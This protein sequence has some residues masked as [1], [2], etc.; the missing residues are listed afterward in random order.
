MCTHS[1][2]W[3]VLLEWVH[4]DSRRN[5]LIN[6]C[7][8]W[9]V[10]CQ[11]F[12]DS[13]VCMRLY[14]LNDLFKEI[15][16]LFLHLQR[17]LL[18]CYLF[19]NNQ[20]HFSFRGYKMMSEFF[21]IF[22]YVF[23][24]EKA[25]CNPNIVWLKEDVPM[26]IVRNK[27]WHKEIVGLWEDPLLEAS[28]HEAV[29]FPIN[30]FRSL[31]KQRWKRLS[32]FRVKIFHDKFFMWRLTLRLFFLRQSLNFD[33]PVFLKRWRYWSLVTK[34]V[35]LIVLPIEKYNGRKILSFIRF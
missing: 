30:F 23:R 8:G 27:P 2:V 21:S 35:S 4:D 33:G 34:S 19:P 32:W 31:I 14:L 29:N 10:A 18:R 24:Q 11:G 9:E 3:E 6:F 25:D 22:I 28:V 7:C 15:I 1:L 16:P 5:C 13:L 12:N 17:H 20:L 26:V